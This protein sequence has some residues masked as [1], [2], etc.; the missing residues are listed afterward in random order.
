MARLF[1]LLKIAK[2]FSQSI[3]IL[4]IVES[5][6]VTPSTISSLKLFSLIAFIIHLM[7]CVWYFNSSLIQTYS[8]K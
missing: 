5:I 7:S 8:T 6:Q 4:S 2:I 1:R 3:L